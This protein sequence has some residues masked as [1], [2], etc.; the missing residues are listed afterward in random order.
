MAGSKPKRA[1]SIVIIG[2]GG[3][4]RD[5]HLPAYGK[6]GFPVAGIFDRDHS[7]SQVLASQFRIPRVYEDLDEAV[8]ETP[9]D[10][11]FDVAV[12]ASAILEILPRLPDGSGVLIQKPWG[13]NLEQATAIRAVGSNSRSISASATRSRASPAKVERFGMPDRGS[14]RCKD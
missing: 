2:A 1:R 12:P 4:V 11:V 3:I 10:S 5:A 8:R 9:A 14:I 7:R 13:E 6:A